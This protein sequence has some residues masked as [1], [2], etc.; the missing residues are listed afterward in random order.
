MSAGEESGEEQADGTCFALD[1]TGEVVLETTD[2]LGELVGGQGVR[3]VGGELVSVHTRR[4]RRVIRGR[5]RGWMLRGGSPDAAGFFGGEADA[6]LCGGGAEAAEGFVH[7]FVA[8]AKDAVV[9]GH[10]GAGA[11]VLGHVEGLFGGGVGGEVGVVSADADAGEVDTAGLAEGFPSVEVG[12]VG[13]EEDA[14]LGGFE[15]EAAI[16]AVGVGEDAGA[17]VLE[18]DGGDA[19]VAEGVGVAGGEFVDGGETEVGEEVGAAGG[20]E[21]GGV[22][23]IAGETAE[24]GSVEVVEVGVGDEQGVEPGQVGEG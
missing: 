23:V 24:G 13:T 10:D 2:M 6:G 11:G 9:D 20:G 7:G 21:D 5:G 17:P 19:E 14:V 3:S 15:E 8:E 12:G 16:A 18:G 1:D 22:G 4:P